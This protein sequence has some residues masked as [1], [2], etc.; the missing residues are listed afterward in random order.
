MTGYASVE[1]ALT[2]G[3][4]VERSFRCPVHDD[5]NPS[6][7]V[8]S[9]T[10]MWICY[11]CGARGRVDMEKM[12]IPI[13]SVLAE[14]RRVAQIMER[15]VHKTYPESWLNIY[16]AT[17]PGDY[18][19]SRFSP[20]ACRHFRLG[21]DPADEFATYPYRDV[22]GQVLGVVRRNFEG[23]AKYSYPYGS[24][25]SK[26]LF[27]YHAT[28]G[29]EIVVVEGAT[30]AIAAWEAGYEAWALY[31]DRLSLAQQRLIAKYSPDRL[32][33][34]TDQDAAGE[35]AAEQLSRAF[36]YLDVVRLRWPGRD[37][38]GWKDLSEMPVGDRR[39][40]LASTG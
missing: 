12:E 6:A 4:G 28:S 17:G 36:P 38:G 31:G 20:E 7:S 27:N 9:L 40:V 3:T 33:V 26:N 30:D 21:T 29:G 25:T 39:D 10:G 8:N 11:T 1:E 5:S 19:L 18:W 14:M 32:L 34:A 35:F 13:D 37:A 15:P 2:M 24:D 16:D 22:S 23:R